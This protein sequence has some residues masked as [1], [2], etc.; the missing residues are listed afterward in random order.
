LQISV[1]FTSEEAKSIVAVA[2]FKVD[3]ES[4]TI[5]LSAIGKVPFITINY[6][7]LDFG[8]LS[9]GKSLTKDLLLYNES[10]VSANFEIATDEKTTNYF[11]V[12]PKTGCI[13]SKQSFKIDVTYTP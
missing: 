12:T 8:E 3:A 4:R 11:D 6:E 5:K 2:I 9:V 10:P 7:K 13:P 1:E